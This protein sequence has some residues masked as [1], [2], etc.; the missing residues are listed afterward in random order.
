[1]SCWLK[2]CLEKASS[3]FPVAQQKDSSVGR[4]QR[5]GGHDSVAQLLERRGEENAAKMAACGEP[6]ATMA[7]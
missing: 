6:S 2:A 4:L 5:H 7:R 3:C 1:M